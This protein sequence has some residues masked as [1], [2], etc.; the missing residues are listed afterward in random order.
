MI[1][2]TDILSR[3]AE[4]GDEQLIFLPDLTLWY[5]WHTRR[6]SLPDKWKTYSL[7]EIAQD[8]GWPVWLAVRP[9]KAEHPGVK[10]VT[11]EEGQERVV[12]TETSAGTLTARWSLGPDGDWWQTEYPVKNAEELEAVLELVNSRTYTLDTT[13][14]TRTTELVGDKGVVAIELPRRPYSDLLYDFLGL[15]DGLMLL[16]EPPVQ[17]ILRLL[18]EKLQHVVEKIIR[19]PGKL[20]LSQDN[21]DGQFISPRACKKYLTD[22]YRHTTNLLHQ[23]NK[24]LIVHAGGPLKRL[25]KPLVDAGIDGIEGIS[26]PPQSD[27]SL[28]E[29]REL[30]GSGLTLWGGIPQGFLLPIHESHIFEAAMKQAAQEARH[31]GR[32][33][34]G[35]ADRVPVDAE[36]ARLEAISELINQG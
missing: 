20:I 2:R 34:L 16:G 6:E 10:V 19:L 30:A 35:I 4:E 21:L 24:H 3:F 23:H 11:S 28:A 13:E 18:E 27:T 12:R 36:L 33:I 31:D 22:S 8:L 26:G 32:M 15:S 29:A 25:I 7:P 9:W 5:D 17:E 14:L 1:A